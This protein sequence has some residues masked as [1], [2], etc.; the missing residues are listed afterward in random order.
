MSDAT[1]SGIGPVFF[2]G[3]ELCSQMSVLFLYAG[4]SCLHV[5][6]EYKSDLLFSCGRRVE[7][8][9][10]NLKLHTN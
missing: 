8:M 7:R 1:G 3:V 6:T 10:G 2:F 5:G 4:N 9:I